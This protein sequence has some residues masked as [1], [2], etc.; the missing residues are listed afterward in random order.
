MVL[1]GTLCLELV[2][3]VPASILGPSRVVAIHMTSSIAL[4]AG[5]VATIQTDPVAIIA[6]VEAIVVT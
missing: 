6:L 3:T 2:P 4:V 1:S 5:F